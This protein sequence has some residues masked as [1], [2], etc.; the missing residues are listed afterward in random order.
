[1]DKQN[2]VEIKNNNKI[3]KADPGAASDYSFSFSQRSSSKESKRVKN[4]K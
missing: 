3:Q 1:M 2:G 4:K